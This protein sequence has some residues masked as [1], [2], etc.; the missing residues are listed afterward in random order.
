[1]NVALSERK[2]P[3]VGSV[4][5]LVAL[6]M[7]VAVEGDWGTAY[8]QTVPVG[9]AEPLLVIGVLPATGLPGLPTIDITAGDGGGTVPAAR[10]QAVINTGAGAPVQASISVPSPGDAPVGVIVQPRAL[11][12]LVSPELLP[13]GFEPIGAL[14]VQV[15]RTDTGQPVTEHRRPIIVELSITDAML[16]AAD[17]DP[18]RLGM[19][20]INPGTGQ[21][22]RLPCVADLTTRRLICQTTRTS[23]FAVVTLPPEEA[24]RSV[25]QADIRYFPQTFF[26]IDDDQFFDYFHKRGGVNTFGYPVS[27]TFILDGMPTQVFQRHVM[28]LGPDGSVRTL[29]LLDPGLMPFTTINF[30]TF[31]AV[32]E[33]VKAETPLVGEP[34]YGQRIIEFVRQNAPDEFEGLPVNFFQTFMSTVKCS[35]AFPDGPCQEDLL[36]LLNLEIWGAPTSRPAR[37]PHNANFI[38]LRFQRGIMHF[39]ATTGVTQG[40][41]LAD[42]FKSILTG[43]NLPDDLAQQARGSRFFRQYLDIGRAGLVDPAALPGSD[44]KNAF[45]LDTPRVLLRP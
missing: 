16:A 29:N 41:L 2:G 8:G 35:D 45:E 15:A 43:R 3:I 10:G 9:P 26:R 11:E 39:D 14:K 37:D 31:P 18:N 34:D 36:P 28:Q 25:V 38:Y 17:N 12:A 19:L 20:R 13:P 22:E 24:A 42:Y 32:D 33:G 23:V 21:V 4:V 5:A 1:M 40:L 7:L 44:L 6:A 30:S 27:R